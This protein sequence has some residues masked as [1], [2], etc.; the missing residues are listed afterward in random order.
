MKFYRLGDVFFGQSPMIQT[1]WG[2]MM[3]AHFFSRLES[4]LKDNYLRVSSY[5]YYKLLFKNLPLVVLP[6]VSLSMI[7]FFNWIFDGDWVS[8]KTFLF[9]DLSYLSVTTVEELLQML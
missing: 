8:S 9:T 6:S 3:A 2:E 4:P 7:F 1:K 5:L